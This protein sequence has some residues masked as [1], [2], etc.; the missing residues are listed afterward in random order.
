MANGQ[1]FDRRSLTAAAHWVPLGSRIRVFNLDNGRYMD[2]TV[3]D[4][5][6]SSRFSSRVLDLSEAAAKQLG[7]TGKGMTPVF[8]TPLPETQAVPYGSALE[9][10][11]PVSY[12]GTSPRRPNDPNYGPIN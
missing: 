5:G 3:T 1:H 11:Q 8:F 6:P 2:V 4:R 9:L 10:E 12:P 7:F